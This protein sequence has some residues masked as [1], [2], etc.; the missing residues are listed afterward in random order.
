VG[1]IVWMETLPDLWVW[2]GV[3]RL[4]GFGSFDRNEYVAIV[5][6]ASEWSHLWIQCHLR[7][8]F[9]EETRASL[10]YRRQVLSVVESHHAFVVDIIQS[11]R[12]ELPVLS[13]LEESRKELWWLW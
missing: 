2:F 8:H 3:R 7:H 11:V 13:A 12:D 5:E 6:D 4:L 10:F 1:H 9:G